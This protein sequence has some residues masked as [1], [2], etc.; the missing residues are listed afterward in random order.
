MINSDELRFLTL[1]LVFLL[2]ACTGVEASPA[3]LPV[4]VVQPASDSVEAN[5]SA[6]DDMEAEQPQAAPLVAVEQP[7]A[8]E[9]VAEE[10]VST[11]MDEM[12]VAAEAAASARAEATPEETLASEP[13]PTPEQLELLAG[14]QAKGI[15][16]ELHNQV[17]LNSE[18]LK[19]A[20]L[21]GKVVIVE[22]W[23]FG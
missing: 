20:E 7:A 18:P 13:G 5:I 22:F 17:W 8:I 23:T 11:D 2:A 3:R 19:L 1:G 14:L 9:P 10:A 21:H 16:P 15:P 4:E 12:G 6:A